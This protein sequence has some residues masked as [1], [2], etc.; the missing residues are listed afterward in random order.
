MSKVL[1]VSD[2]HG[3][4][5]E[6]NELK[7]RHKDVEKFIHCGD[8]ELSKNDESIDQFIVV[9]GNCDY[10]SLFHNDEVIDFQG[11]KFLVT[12]G[13]LYNVKSTLMNLKYKAEEV[14]A[15][16]VCFGH[17]HLLGIEK[18]GNILFLNPGSLRLPRGRNER[19]YVVLNFTEQI[20]DLHVYDFDQG[21]IVQL[22]QSFQLH[23]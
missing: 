16:I 21:E 15:N 17:S 2:S 6:L 19:T 23:I 3:L 1:I 12:H 20:V 14:N 4:T 11:T 7:K 5:E 18:I 22:R 13:H 10:E 9:R 8:S